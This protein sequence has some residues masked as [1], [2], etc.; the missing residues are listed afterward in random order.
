MNVKKQKKTQK[1]L[2]S[3]KN[4]IKTKQKKLIKKK[5][6]KKCLKPGLV[7]KNMEV[8][9]WSARFFSKIAFEL[10]ETN[11]FAGC[12]DW[13][14]SEHGGLSTSLLGLKRHP[15]LKELVVSILL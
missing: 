12:W 14:I 11:L 10:G 8:A 3:M 4:N 9:S 5:N 1:I 7:S 15:D 6:K 2:K 13:F